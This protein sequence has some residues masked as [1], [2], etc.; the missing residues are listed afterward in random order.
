MGNQKQTHD[1]KTNQ[2][3]GGKLKD[4]CL[5]IGYRSALGSLKNDYHFNSGFG[6]DI[7][8]QYK[9]AGEGHID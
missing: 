6:F 5:S 9:I 2:K 7:G 3:K 4:F 8:K 1:T